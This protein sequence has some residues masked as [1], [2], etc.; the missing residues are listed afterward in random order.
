MGG[1]RAR[2]L[3]I[4][5]SG[6]WV[7]L[8]GGCGKE[9]GQAPFKSA[10]LEGSVTLDGKPIGDGTIQFVPASKEA[11]GVTQATIVEGRYVA[12][13][14]ALG[15]VT[16][17]LFTQPPPAPENLSTDYKPES[18]A[19]IPERYKKGFKIEVKEDQPN[20]DFAMSSK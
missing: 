11:G 14:V 5:I 17:M 9:E 12:P 20:V 2:A 4:I 13:R 19:A 15:Q 8:A 10:R 18:F 16:A 3:L 6:V 1:H 7:P